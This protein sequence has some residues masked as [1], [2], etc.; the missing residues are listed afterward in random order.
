MLFFLFFIWVGVVGWVGFEMD[1]LCLCFCC[2]YFGF[3]LDI[4]LVFFGCGVIVLFGYL[5]FGKSICLCCIV[6][7][8]KVVEGEVMINGEIW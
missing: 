6:G 5:G 4:D 7:L 8:E 1:G 3:E 2:V